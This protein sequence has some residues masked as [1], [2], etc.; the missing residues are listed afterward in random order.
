MAL[1]SDPQKRAKQLKN[2]KP[3]PP[4]PKGAKRNLT[5]GATATPS[6]RRQAALERQIAAALPVRDADGSAPAADAIAVRLL[7]VALCRH[8]SCAR[9]V[10]KH[11]AIT[12]G[13]KLSAAAEWEDKLYARCLRLSEQ[14]GLTPA[15]RVKLG[16][17]LAQTAQFDLAQAM[18]DIPDART[19]RKRP[20]LP[21]IDGTVSD[22]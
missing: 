15:S 22:E 21:D 16:L 3:A 17:T 2:L 8:E 5:H 19:P 4:T 18:S 9:Y 14:L 1:S 20:Q 13:G 12:R 11:G 7:A 10:T 6:P